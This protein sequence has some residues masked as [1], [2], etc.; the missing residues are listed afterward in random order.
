MRLSIIVAMDDNR[1][2]GNNNALPWHLPAD[3]AYFK[4]TTTGKTVLMGRKTFD[5]IGKPLP[6]RRNIVLSSKAQSDSGHYETAKNIRAAL[7]KCR[8]EDEVFIIG[9]MSV[10]NQ[11][12]NPQVSGADLFATDPIPLIDRLYLTE[13]N[14]SFEG[15]AHFPE[16]DR[17]AFNEISRESH[18]ADEKNQHNYHFTIL[19]KK[20]DF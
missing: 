5:S 6:N 1:L 13:V 2:I 7:D 19:E 15:D 3:L 8:N 14:G 18:L 17:S 12:I 20:H 16:F 4:K 11:F 9:G 10:Y